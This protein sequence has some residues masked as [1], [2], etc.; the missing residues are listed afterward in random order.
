MP[1]SNQVNITIQLIIDGKIIDINIVSFTRSDFIVFGK[2]NYLI[3]TYKNYKTNTT[4]IELRQPV[5][6]FSSFS[7]VT[8]LILT[9]YSTDFICVY[10]YSTASP[11]MI[12]Q[13][14]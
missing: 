3:N 4:L 12:Y 10:N 8:E 5:M 9:P 7:V 2:E 11:T 13:P 6:F 1:S 14:V